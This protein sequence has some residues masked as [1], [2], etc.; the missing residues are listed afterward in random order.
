MCAKLQGTRNSM[1]RM[2]RELERSVSYLLQGTRSKEQRENSAKV[3][4]SNYD[5]CHAAG[6]KKKQG[7]KGA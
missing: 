2:A 1:V 4:L 6:K 3:K 7:E 5:A